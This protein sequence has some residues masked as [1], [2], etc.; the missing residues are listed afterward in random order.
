MEENLF[1]EMSHAQPWGKEQ[2]ECAVKVLGADHIIYGSSYPVRSEWLTDGPDFVKQLDISSEAKELILE[3][4][5]K[6]LYH[7]KD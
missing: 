4:N 7:I 5:A 6:R 3:G 1:F 2:L